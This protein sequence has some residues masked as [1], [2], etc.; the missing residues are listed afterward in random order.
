[1]TDVVIFGTGSF[2]EL[3][4]VYLTSDERYDVVAFSVSDDLFDEES[5]TLRDRPIVK[6]SDLDHHFDRAVTKVFV[7]I[8][9]RGMNAK[10]RE[11]CL[12]LQ[13]KGFSLLTYVHPS[14]IQHESHTIGK[15]VFIFEDNTVQPFVKLGD[16][17]VLWS[18]NHIG[19]HSVIDDWVFVASHVVIFWELTARSLMECASL[20]QISSAQVRFCKRIR[21]LGRFGLPTRQKS[22]LSLVHFF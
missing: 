12:G 8:G 6:L 4:D 1:M 21:N 19:H 15:N 14:V 10:R 13:K 2:A 22:F 18:G 3:V 7:A 9:Y 17:V 5:P 16:G 20:P 11:F